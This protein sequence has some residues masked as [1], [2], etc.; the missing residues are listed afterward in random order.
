MG[1]YSLVERRM[2]IQ[3][4]TIEGQYRSDVEFILSVNFFVLVYLKE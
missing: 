3:Y 2:V 4:G 1:N